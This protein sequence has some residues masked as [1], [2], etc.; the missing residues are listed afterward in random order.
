MYGWLLPCCG[1]H[2]AVLRERLLVPPA[3]APAAAQNSFWNVKAVNGWY[4]NALA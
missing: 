3:V 1:G 4:F 2:A